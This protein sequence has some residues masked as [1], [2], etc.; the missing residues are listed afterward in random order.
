MWGS[1]LLVGAG[2]AA[3][4]VRPVPAILFAQAANGILMPAVAIFLLIVVNDR[5]SMG[6][7]ANGPVVNLLGGTVVAGTLLLGVRA[8]LGAFGVL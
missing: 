7:P 5:R 8:I 1:V 3:A 6:R 4:G 2:F